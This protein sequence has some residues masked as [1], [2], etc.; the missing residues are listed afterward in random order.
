MSAIAGPVVVENAEDM[1]LLTVGD[2]VLADYHYKGAHYEVRQLHLTMTSFHFKAKLEPISFGAMPKWKPA[3]RAQN[4]GLVFQDHVLYGIWWL[5]DTAVQETRGLRAE[6]LNRV[7]RTAQKQVHNS[8]HPLWLPEVN[9]YLGAGHYSQSTGGKDWK[10]GSNY[11]QFMMLLDAKPPFQMRNRTGDFCF[12]SS[13]PGFRDMC[14]KVQ[15]IMSM[16]RDPKDPKQILISYGIQDCRSIVV[17]VPL[18]DILLSMAGVN[19]SQQI[20]F[21]RVS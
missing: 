20:E 6:N 11:L 3:Y 4:V 17:K 8:I 18:K 19:S 21:E 12:P 9:G 13:D 10:W 14:E 1:R 15:F 2:V 5:N 7:E 16:I